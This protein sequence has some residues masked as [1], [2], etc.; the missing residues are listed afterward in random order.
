VDRFVLLWIW[1]AFGLLLL[2]LM[3]LGWRA[4]RR[5]QS[6][7]AVPA[8][9]P[10]ELGTPLA[11]SEGKYVA[12]TVAGEPLQRIAVHGL[13][14]R[15]DVTAA[16]TDLGI[17]LVM[18]GRDIWIPAADLTGVG[19]ATWTIDRVVERDGL[20]TLGWR[21]G[22]REVETALRL[23]DPQAFEAATQRLLPGRTTA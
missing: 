16:V 8:S 10:A 17:L 12:T 3:L 23:D 20:I 19:R 6:S 9:R 11:T 21:L 4:L 7:V 14:F 2:V 1:I 5:R 15:G 18:V 22:D 13:G